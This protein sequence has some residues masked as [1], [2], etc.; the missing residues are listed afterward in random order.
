MKRGCAFCGETVDDKDAV[1]MPRHEYDLWAAS[2]QGISG[3]TNRLFTDTVYVCEFCYSGKKPEKSEK[4]KVGDWVVVVDQHGVEYNAIVFYV[5]DK[6]PYV[7]SL[8]IGYTQK[9]KD[10][11]KF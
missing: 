8:P 6:V 5:K 10:N 2:K 4:I 3:H 9:E 11:D 7:M 1:G